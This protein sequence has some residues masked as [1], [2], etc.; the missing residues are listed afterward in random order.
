MAEMRRRYFAAALCILAFLIAQTFQELAFLFW[1][2]AANSVQDDLATRLLTID[3]IRA[4]LVMGS[5]GLLIIAYVVIALRYRR[6]APIASLLGLI[7]GAAFVGFEVV[8]RS[9][10]FFVV[11]RHW[12][13]QFHDAA[14]GPVS[15]AVLQRFSLWNEMVQGWYFPQMLSHMLC[16]SAFAFATLKETGSWARLAT[17]AFTLNAL[18]LLGRILSTFAGVTWLS[19]LN[20][21]FYFPA[22]FV[23]NSL[24]VGWLL[25]LAKTGMEPPNAPGRIQR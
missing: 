13:Q 21:K 5:I 2:P 8:A 22:V 17:T 12:A 10:D 1:I 20:D 14:P 11:G 15:D 19:G 25:H 24:L 7:F 23:I 4:L 9:I 6:V 3:K 16:S 18:R